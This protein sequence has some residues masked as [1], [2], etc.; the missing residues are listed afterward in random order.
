MGDS[1]AQ[2][3]S[4]MTKLRGARLF[5]SIV[6]MIAVA[7]VSQLSCSPPPSEQPGRVVSVQ[8][9]LI[10]TQYSPHS[11][12]RFHASVIYPQTHQHYFQP[13]APSSVKATIP[14]APGMFGQNDLLYVYVFLEFTDLPTE[15][16][17]QFMDE[18]GSWEHRAFWGADMIPWGT[19]NTASR[20]QICA[21]MGCISKGAWT[22]ITVSASNIG[23]VGHRAVG[24]AY[25]LYGGKAFWDETGYMPNGS[26]IDERPWFD[27]ALPAGAIAYSSSDGWHWAAAKRDWL[28]F[29][30]DPAHSGNNQ[31][32]TQISPAN[33]AGLRLM[34]GF[35]SFRM[36]HPSN[37][38]P[39]LLKDVSIGGATHDV[40]YVNSGGNL[41]A[42]DAYTGQDILR[43]DPQL[44]MTTD[45]GESSPAIDP[46]RQWVYNIGNDRRIHKYSA[47]TLTE[48][49][50]GWALPTAER[51]KTSPT[52]AKVNGTTFLYVGTGDL[53][54]SC[55]FGHLVTVNLSMPDPPSP[56]AVTTLQ[57]TGG[58]WA[59]GG[60][61]FD[62]TKQRILGATGDVNGPFN[63]A[64][65]VIPVTL[66]AV[67]F[68]GTAIL[69]SYTPANEAHLNSEDLDLGSTNTQ[70][71]PNTGYYSRE[72]VAAQ[73][74]KDG[75]ARLI[76]LDNMSGQGVPG[77]FGGEISSTGLATL[78][79]PLPAGCAEGT[80]Q[81]HVRGPTAS[82]I[83][84]SDGRYWI[85]VNAPT[86]MIALRYEEF[87]Q[88]TFLNTIWSTPPT[89]RAATK[90]G[91]AFVANGVLYYANGDNT[92]SN[93]MGLKWVTALTGLDASGNFPTTGTTDA[94]DKRTPLVVNGVVYYNGMAWSLA[95]VPPNTPNRALRRSASQSTD[96]PGFFGFAY[97]ANDGSTEG[98]F[99]KGS[100]NHTDNQPTTVNGL[101]GFGGPWWKVDLG[102]TFTINKV[103]LH[104]RTDAGQ[105]RISNFR[106]A[107][108]NTS[109]TGPFSVVY[110]STGT[111]SDPVILAAFQNVNARWVMVQK[112][113][114]TSNC[115]TDDDFM[116][117]AE[118]QV[119]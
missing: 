28:Q 118:V 81:C 40:L 7:W 52:I 112:V 65:G 92:D 85:F 71:F 99:F 13:L 102:S 73:V 88:A 47:T 93:K 59:R 4:L 70:L 12:T 87:H 54:G 106:I 9:S 109:S 86:G 8:S 91:G 67:K 89:V 108:S 82:W 45:P 97:L 42:I 10:E 111:F 39:V 20:R 76:D 30:G 49:G 84:P 101:T 44:T 98:D 1:N 113:C 61:P 17:L 41:F 18:T 62:A 105:S 11:G 24:A 34:L 53:V 3:R 36:T 55:C 22:R 60:L 114:S 107:V 14:P 90:V 5:G 78:S 94:N 32:E 51:S 104:N 74:G 50:T 38:P 115:R 68:D 80:Q 96:L 110:S 31:L 100:V 19:L 57:T 58:L 75:Y 16:M 25:T 27:D 63:F 26:S 69:D 33:M 37:A 35:N 77:Q 83:D 95:G 116:N 46:S 56:A 6:S 29:G 72:H 23:M 66:L 79:D 64:N 2:G 117:L 15:L 48:V 119:F 103:V 21:S 43:G